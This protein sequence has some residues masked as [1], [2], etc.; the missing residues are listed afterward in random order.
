MNFEVQSDTNR[1]K[2]FGNQRPNTLFEVWSLDSGSERSERRKKDSKVWIPVIALAALLS[3]TSGQFHQP[4][5]QNGFPQTQSAF[6]HGAF[7]HTGFPLKF[8]KQAIYFPNQNSVCNKS[9]MP[10]HS[11][12]L[13]QKS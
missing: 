4:F 8:R 1:K 5:P 13:S 10:K 2:K 12:K 3:H 11:S 9:L 6:P 7:P